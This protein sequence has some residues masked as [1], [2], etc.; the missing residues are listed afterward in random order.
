[1]LHT[2]DLH[3]LAGLIEGEGSFGF[4]HSSLRLTILMTDRDVM[5]RVSTLLGAPVRDLAPRPN[6]K[7]QFRVTVYGRVAAGWAMTLWSLMGE[8]RRAKISEVLPKW[9][10]Q[11]QH[12][13]LCRKGHSMSGDN[14]RL[15]SERQ[16]GPVNARTRRICLTCQRAAMSAAYQRRSSKQVEA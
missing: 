16:R 2:N 7:P 15:Y 9:R 3:W 12:G 14:V 8:R 4:Y 13:P 6:A 11:Q 10:A 1:M 5:E